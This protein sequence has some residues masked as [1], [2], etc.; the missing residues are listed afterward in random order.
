[1]ATTRSA[2]STHLA[3]FHTFLI[4]DSPMTYVLCGAAGPRAPRTTVRACSSRDTY[5][6]YPR[7]FRDNESHCRRSSLGRGKCRGAKALY[8]AVAV[9][10]CD[11]HDAARNANGAHPTAGS[12]RIRLLE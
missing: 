6:G 7:R 3:T 11:T 10:Y 4:T 5:H 1:M 12:R 2:R 9:L 8:F